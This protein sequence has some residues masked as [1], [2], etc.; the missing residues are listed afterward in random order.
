MNGV[1]GIVNDVLINGKNSKET[2][3]EDKSSSVINRFADVETRQEKTSVPQP[4]S[5]ADSCIGQMSKI[6]DSARG[7]TRGEK[8]KKRINI[9]D[10]ASTADDPSAPVY[11]PRSPTSDIVPNKLPSRHFYPTRNI[12]ASSDH[13]E[14]DA[15]LQVDGSAETLFQNEKSPLLEAGD[16]Q[17]SLNVNVVNITSKLNSKLVDT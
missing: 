8:S 17:T 12:Q 15:L 2:T 5:A 14:H 11:P 4:V 13:E 6:T 7:T 9:M 1:K 16:A 10:N 3:A